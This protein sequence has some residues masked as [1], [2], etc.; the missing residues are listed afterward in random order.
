LL[1]E[2]INDRVFFI[3][4]C[5]EFKA[6]NEKFMNGGKLFHLGRELPMREEINR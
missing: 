6:E 1:K 3:W 4:P 5:L 2:V